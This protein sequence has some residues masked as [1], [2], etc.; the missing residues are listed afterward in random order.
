MGGDY[1]DVIIFAAIAAFLVFRLLSVLGKRTGQEGSRDPFGIARNADI[2]QGGEK[3][4]KLPLTHGKNDTGDETNPITPLAAAIKS[5]KS[6]LLRNELP[7]EEVITG[8]CLLLAGAF[9]L[10]PGFLTDFLG[11]LLFIARF[12]IFLS[13]FI[14]RYMRQQ[15]FSH[16]QTTQNARDEDFANDHQ[17]SKIIDGEFHEINDISEQNYGRTNTKRIE[18]P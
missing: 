14:F 5:I 12:R 17:F 6:A 16:A 8:L 3:P 7:F 4:E 15:G 1:V 13:K 18:T 2:S 11:F 9:L 10:T